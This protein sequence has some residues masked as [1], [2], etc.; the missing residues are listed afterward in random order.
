MTPVSGQQ[1]VVFQ[2]TDEKT[3]DA[4]W[5]LKQIVKK[6]PGVRVHWIEGARHHLAN[7]IARLRQPV[8]NELAQIIKSD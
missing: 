5:N 6:F 2:G 1:V 3:V 4:P 8:L 7:E